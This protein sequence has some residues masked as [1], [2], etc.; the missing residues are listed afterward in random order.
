MK[1]ECLVELVH[2]LAGQDPEELPDAFDVHGP[3]L[4]GLRL[5]VPIEAGRASIEEHLERPRRPTP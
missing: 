1:S 5:G 4:L 3:Y 2:E